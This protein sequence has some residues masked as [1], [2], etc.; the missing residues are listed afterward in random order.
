MAS[1]SQTQRPS[2][3]PDHSPFTVALDA[4]GGD[5]GPGEIVPGAIQAARDLGV[6]VLL[7]GDEGL[8]RQALARH[9]LNGLR[10]DVVPSQGVIEEMDHPLAAMREKPR[11]SVV[12]AAR[13]V[14]A[15]RAQAMVSMGSTGAAMATSALVFGMLEG[16]ERPAIGG[17]VLAPLSNAVLLDLGSNVDCRPSQM[18]GFG[19]IGVAFARR[20]QG[21]HNPR[22][23]ILSVGSE[24]GKGNRQVKEVYHLFK[25]SSLNFVGNVE[26][27]D[28][29]GDKADVIVCDGFVGNILLKFTEGLGTA[30]A[31]R[32]AEAA[33]SA[34]PA[35]AMHLLGAELSSMT[36]AVDL[37]GGGPLFGVNG[38]AVIGH[39]RSRAPSIARAVA[40]AKRAV[41]FGLVEAMQQ[42]LAAI[43]GQ[44]K[45]E[46]PEGPP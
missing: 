10:L 18:L 42:E 39:G 45:R 15:G 9:S 5:Y 25:Q 6:G 19:A 12:E 2:G 4:M 3:G 36:N 33:S 22:V 16:V 44:I 14:K 41:D 27:I 1:H 26:G 30:L 7:V 23:G 13:L 29:F 40:L 31:R 37:A 8:V 34:L 38:I 43:Q 32:L 46:A 35:S 24:E 28:V 11:A 20:V 17:P 21:V